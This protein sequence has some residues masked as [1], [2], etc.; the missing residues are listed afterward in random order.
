MTTAG[1]LQRAATLWPDALYVV[2]GDRRWTYAAFLDYVRSVASGLQRLGV[3]T[4]D[5]VALWMANRAE[6]L[7]TDFACGLLGAVLVP[8]NTRLTAREVAYVLRQSGSSVL[9]MDRFFRQQ[10]LWEAY[11]SVAAELPDVHSVVLCGEVPSDVPAVVRAVVPFADLA[12]P[13]WDAAGEAGASAGCTTAGAPA[14]REAP[15]G[16]PDPGAPAYILYTSGTTS[17]PKGVVLTH[18]NV[19]RN[20]AF[21]GDVL[22]FQP[23]DR[24]LVAL[25]LFSSFACLTVKIGCTTH[26]V[27]LILLEH[28]SPLRALEVIGAEAVTVFHAVDTMLADMVRLVESG[29]GPR[30]PPPPRRG[31]APR[32]AGPAAAV[33]RVLGVEHVFAGYGLTEASA[34]SS[35]YRLRE[36]GANL[37]VL[38]PLPLVELKVVE[39]HSGQ[40]VPPGGQGEI[41]VR[42]PGVMQ[43]YHGHPEETARVVDE[44]GWLHTGDLGE[45]LPDGRVRF[46]GRI[47]DVIKTG[48][49]NVSPLEVEEV[50]KAHS[51][52]AEACVVGVPDERLGEVGAAVVRLKDC[53]I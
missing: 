25:P 53:L 49:F 6:W 50:L 27:A 48:G 15:L 47:K 22:D 3:R 2:D 30:P 42:S 16:S 29:R 5:R 40:A 44:E 18:R 17:F 14:E 19:V 31:G 52:V 38:E 12:I 46:L 21:T 10:D 51:A 39:P 23:G 33:R 43:G 26:G 9:V 20:C 36:D 4:G 24:A 8:V 28:F 35:F 37:N 1:V 13:R 11:A 34:A 32:P 41:C 45:V 7:A